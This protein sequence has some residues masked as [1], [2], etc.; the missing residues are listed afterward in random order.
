M[1]HPQLCGPGIGRA[2]SRSIFDRSGRLTASDSQPQPRLGSPTVRPADR[3]RQVAVTLRATADFPKSFSSP[4]AVL[5]RVSPCAG[6][7]GFKHGCSRRSAGGQWEAELGRHVTTAGQSG[8]RKFKFSTAFVPC[9]P[10]STVI[11]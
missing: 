6:I 2:F 8:A 1:K 5:L 3:R 9:G 11:R 7:E 4:P 10:T